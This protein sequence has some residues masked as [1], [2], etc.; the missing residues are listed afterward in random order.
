MNHGINSNQ[1]LGGPGFPRRGSQPV[2]VG[3]PTYYFD[4]FSHKLREIKKSLLYNPVL[5][6]SSTSVTHHLATSVI[7]V[8]L[9]L[10]KEHVLN[11]HTVSPYSLSS[12]DT[13]NEFKF[14]RL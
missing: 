9:S 13:A 4:H 8:V 3:A 6:K 10:N 12:R 14:N 1:T 2:R 5:L 7:S 11:V